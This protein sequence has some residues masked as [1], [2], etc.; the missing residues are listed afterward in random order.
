MAVHSQILR[1]NVSVSRF[2]LDKTHE[3]DTGRHQLVS[4]LPVRLLEVKSYSKVSVS[5]RSETPPVNTFLL[6]GSRNYFVV[7]RVE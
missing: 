5:Q 4:L 1:I 3:I 2:L 6:D 7:R